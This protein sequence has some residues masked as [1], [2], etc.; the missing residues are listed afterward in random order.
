MSELFATYP[1]QRSPLP[2]EYEAI[3][4]QHYADNRAGRGGANSLAQRAEEWMHRQVARRGRPGE[5]VLDFG[6][7]NLNHYRHERGFERYDVVEPFKL[8][9]EDAP[10]DALVGDTFSYVHDI[11]GRSYDRIFSIAVLEHL[12][13]LPRD[14]ARCA[15]L[16]KPG[17]LFQA[18]IPCEG[19]LGWTLGYMLSTGVAFRMKYGLDYR[20]VVRHEHVNSYKD[21]LAVVGTIFSRVRVRRSWFPAPFPHASFYAYLEAREPRMD[22][23]AALLAGR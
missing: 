16:L 6:A 20:V 4:A 9:L 14:V 5:Q 21:I 19:E 8:L 12:V 10:K 23:V 2:P 22:V 1:R 13:E 18:G 15:S 7:G 11:G 17:G 3:F